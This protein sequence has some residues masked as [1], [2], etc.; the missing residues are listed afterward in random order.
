MWRR[1][2]EPK[3]SSVPQSVVA[4]ASTTSPSA[5]VPPQATQVSSQP[6]AQP[7]AQVAEVAAAPK[8][9]TSIVCKGISIRGQVTGSEDLQIDGEVNGTVQLA[10]GRVMI[11]PEGRVTGNIDARE[12]IVR[13]ELKGNLRAG[14]RILVGRTGV[15]QGDGVSP[16]L[17]IEE[18][19]VVKGKLEV[20]E[21]KKPAAPKVVAA[22][23]PENV[24]APAA[25]A[26]ASSSSSASSGNGNGASLPKEQTGANG[27]ANAH[28]NVTE[29]AKI[30][31]GPSG[32]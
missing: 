20:A 31:T 27:N 9:A 2:E 13:G 29:L 25:S 11:G 32:N 3:V 1:Q 23:K 21:E 10:G 30:G 18:G 7:V 22:P 6:S 12:I 4:P 28:E 14:E 16:R 19:A 15:W 17:G 5:T 24:V 8:T 26:P